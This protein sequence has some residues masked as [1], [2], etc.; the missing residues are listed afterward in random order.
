MWDDILM[1]LNEQ[2]TLLKAL[3]AWGG[4]IHSLRKVSHGINLVYRF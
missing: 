3:S 2:T 4:E 1:R